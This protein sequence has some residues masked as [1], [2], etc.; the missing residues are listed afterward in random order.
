[1]PK[2]QRIYFPF[3][4]NL[5]YMEIEADIYYPEMEIKIVSAKDENALFFPAFLR[6]LERHHQEDLYKAWVDFIA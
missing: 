2:S 3:K 5:H 1:M 6:L 4:Y